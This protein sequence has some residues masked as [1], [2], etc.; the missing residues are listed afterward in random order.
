MS[1]ERLHSSYFDCFSRQTVP[2]TRSE[3]YSLHGITTTV[4]LHQLPTVTTSA[5]S[6]SKLE[7][8]VHWD[9]GNA[10]YLLEQFYQ[11]CSVSSLPE[12]PQFQFPKS[13]VT[14]RIFSVIKESCETVLDFLQQHD[15]FPVMRTPGFFFFLWRTL[16]ERSRVHDVAP[17]RPPRSFSPRRRKTNVQ[18]SQV[19]LH[20]T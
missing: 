12:C 4:W 11:V 16:P 18:R 19:C 17:V 3:K 8:W 6:V 5:G 7:K 10:P 15:V 2:S 9:F 1:L 20:W 13:F 14:F